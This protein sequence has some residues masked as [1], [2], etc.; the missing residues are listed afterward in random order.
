M[1]SAAFSLLYPNKR[2]PILHVTVVSTQRG[3][4]NEHVERL[5]VEGFSILEDFESTV[6][7]N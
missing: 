7:T 4:K 6:G 1:K 2:Y 5:I 3:G